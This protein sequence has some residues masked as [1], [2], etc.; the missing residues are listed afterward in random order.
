MGSAGNGG[1]LVLIEWLD[2][3]Q[4]VASWRFMADIEE[5]VPH[6][7]QTVGHLLHDTENVKVVAVSIA[8][9]DGEWDQACGVMTIPTC[10]V[11][12]MVRL[13]ASSERSAS[14][15]TSA[16]LSCLQPASAQTRQ[17]SESLSS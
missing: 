7:C 10:A 17:S 15:R 5:P 6:R 9:N 4:P 14:G 12:K 16:R 11:V 8:G 3:S 13:T 1:E 2:S